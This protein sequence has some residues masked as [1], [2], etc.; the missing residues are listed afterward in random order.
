MYLYL[1]R[2]PHCAGGEVFSFWPIEGQITIMCLFSELV[3]GT[4]SR[5]A[6]APS[7][8]P[9]AGPWW[10][11]E[12]SSLSLLAGP[13]CPELF[14][15]SCSQALGVWGFA[16]FYPSKKRD[17]KRKRK[18]ERERGRKEKRKKVK[19][20]EQRTKGKKEKVGRLLKRNKKHCFHRCKPYIYMIIKILK[21]SSKVPIVVQIQSF[22]WRQTRWWYTIN[23]LSK[24]FQL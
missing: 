7:I 12:S 6:L 22:W 17:R 8:K 1:I 19:K 14:H 5:S 4:Q 20:E 21:I 3:K 11:P 23:P 9:G 13:I 24:P 15:A 16:L 18:E 2:S 10:T